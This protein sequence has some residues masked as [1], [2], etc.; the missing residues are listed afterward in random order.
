LGHGSQ[1]LLGGQTSTGRPVPE[2]HDTLSSTAPSHTQ[3]SPGQATA[4]DALQLGDTLAR[5]LLAFNSA[6]TL[7]PTSARKQ[8]AGLD[9]RHR[10]ASCVPEMSLRGGRGIFL[11]KPAAEWLTRKAESRKMRGAV[12][13][14]TRVRAY[15]K[16]DD[17]PLSRRLAKM[18]DLAPSLQQP[19]YAPTP[20]ARASQANFVLATLRSRLGE[21][22][23]K[24][25]PP[26]IGRISTCADPDVTVEWAKDY[27]ALDLPANAPIVIFLHTI[28]GTAAQTRWL[29][30]YASSRGWRSCVFVRRGHGDKRL[31]SPTFNILGTIDDVEMQL[32]APFLGMIGVSAGS[33]QLISYLGKAGASTPVGA[34]CAICPAWDVESAFG[35]MK[36]TQ[37]FAEQAMLR[38]IKSHFLRRNRRVLR[39]WDAEAY[40]AC[41]KASSLVELLDAH[42]PFA[43]RQH[44]TTAADYF[45]SHDPMAVRQGVSVPTLL[46]NAEDDFV[47]PA[48]LARPDVIANEQAGALLLLTSAGSHVAFNEGPLGAKSFHTRI[49]F[50]FL[51]AALATARA[52][53]LL[54][55][56]S[57][58]EEES[59]KSVPEPKEIEGKQVSG[60]ALL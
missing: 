28:T 50:D 29:M 33:A 30:T 3:K 10:F 26:F 18:I 1:V 39:G 13:K 11:Q 24:V 56:R 53:G 20:W 57:P 44:G 60:T 8:I 46:L 2:N 40:G 15:W 42:A 16:K 34:A 47:C 5:L 23:R 55:R 17:S 25:E 45:D 4:E 27:A 58:R 31:T 38:K 54:G 12:R 14:F 32:D 59:A 35:K 6:V 19:T 43:L 52:E 48:E 7:R 51:D 21:L 9:A 37:P 49:S 36:E 22:R 41:L